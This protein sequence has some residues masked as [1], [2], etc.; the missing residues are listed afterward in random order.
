MISVRHAAN[1]LSILVSRFVGLKRVFG[2]EDL[3]TIFASIIYDSPKVVGFNMI[4]DI[5]WKLGAVLAVIAATHP[6]FI[7]PHL[8]LNKTFEF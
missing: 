2:F 8:G 1:T 4:S 6:L 3:V 5:G 7:L